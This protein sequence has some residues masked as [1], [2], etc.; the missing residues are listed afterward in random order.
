MRLRALLRGVR[1]ALLVLATATVC[2]LPAMTSAT[3][4]SAAWQA[5]GYERTIG[6]TGTAGVYAW[7]IAYDAMTNQLEVGDYW[8]FFVRSYSM[9]GQ[10]VAS[11]YQS[12]STR[13][14][15]PE[16]IAVDPR[17]GDIWVAENGTQKT[18]GYIAEF[19][20]TGTYLGE[21]NTRS[22][23][24]A[25][26]AMDDQGDLYVVNGHLSGSPSNPNK[27]QVY[28]TNEGGDPET[29]SWGTYGSGPG[30]FMQ[31]MGIA[32]SAAG[33]VYVAD[34]SNLRVSEFD[35]DLSDCAATPNGG[36][37]QDFGVGHFT[38]DLRGVAIDPVN[39]LLY[40]VDAQAGRVEEFNLSGTWITQF[41]SLGT[42]PGQF[43]DGGRQVT[44]DGQGNVWVAD[45]SD[46]RFE[47]FTSA[48]VFEAAYPQPAEPPAPGFLS[49]TRGVAVNPT[50]GTVWV[51]D[52]WNDRFQE[53]APDGAFDATYGHRG[54]TAPYGLD[55][56]RGIGVDPVTG[57]VWV[58]DTRDYYIRIYAENGTY[59]TSLGSGLDSNAPGSF[60]AP[61]DVT[62]HE[63]DGTDYAYISDYW[64]CTVTI[65]NATDNP[66]QYAGQISNLCNNYGVAVDPATGDIYVTQQGGGF[67][68]SPVTEWSPFNPSSPT[69]FSE[70]GHLSS[71]G[72]GTGQLEAPWG[73]DVVNGDVYVSDTKLDQVQVFQT[74]GTYLGHIGSK[75]NAAGQ[76]N[77]PSEIANDAEGDIYVA[78]ANV[79]RVQEFS[80]SVIPPAPGSDTTP[81]TVT[82]TSPTSLQ[83]MP[84]S[85][86]TITGAAT[87]NVAL[88]DME[89]AVHNATTNLWWNGSLSNWSPTK[90][91]NISA[92]VC[93]AMTSCTFSFGFVGE[94]YGGTYTA[95][96]RA[97]DT[98]GNSAT[99]PLVKFTV[100]SS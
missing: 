65:W 4:A 3:S 39:D 98:S 27:V 63:T 86:V 7:G 72:T 83:M 55:Y 64:S 75:G 44:V 88:G 28:N 62:F 14:G 32:V 68:G 92:P 31:A 19:S 29:C 25:W 74:N 49:E 56:P 37:V 84:A 66:P 2:A 23:Y 45:Y 6:G 15:Q 57:D 96:A 76:F 67:F 46:Y 90:E 1:S 77:E 82:L 58:A 93:T 50:D 12:A 47:E 48:G 43:Q 70:I 69:S 20:D 79:G 33:D 10:Q 71:F 16:S 22:E 26:I 35:P 78:D 24:T 36:W 52:A 21:I 61:E 94:V 17:N 80:Y 91:W 13:Q 41:G 85:Q 95:T 89:V 38:G 99:T 11:F 51:A 9:T 53:F 59:L 81:P 87:D 42:G 5:P 60:E 30:E 18:A 73:V 54:S 40:V 34:A 8:N 100:A 97:V